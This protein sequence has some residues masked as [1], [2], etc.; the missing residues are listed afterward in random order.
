MALQQPMLE[1]LANNYKKFGC[2]LEFVTGAMAVGTAWRLRQRRHVVHCVGCP[3]ASAQH[4][5]FLHA[6]PPPPPPSFSC[7]PACLL[8]LSTPRAPS[9]RPQTAPRRATS[10]AR[11]SAALAACCA[12]RCVHRRGQHR[13][14]PPVGVAAGRWAAGVP[15]GAALACSSHA[16]C[17][18]WALGVR[19]PYACMPSCVCVHAHVHRPLL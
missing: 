2:L 11:A 5:A 16:C 1:W 12:T 10:F 3:A 17:E 4:V 8:T 13:L 9:R 18:L 15:P 14:L 19:V 7:T 6:P